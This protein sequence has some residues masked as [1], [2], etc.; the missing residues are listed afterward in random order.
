MD[1]ECW[2]VETVV[3]GYTCLAL[4]EVVEVREGGVEELGVAFDT[5]VGGRAARLA[6]FG[7]CHV[8]VWFGVGF[9]ELCAR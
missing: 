9:E 3:P 7:A 5:P 2:A 4:E 1:P 6:E 8:V